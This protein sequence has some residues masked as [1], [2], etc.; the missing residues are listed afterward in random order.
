EGC[1]HLCGMEAKHRQIAELEQVSFREAHSEG[2]SGIVDDPQ[3]IVGGD[4]L[5]SVHIA[6]AGVAMDRH[7][8]RSLWG[9]SSFGFCRIQIERVG[10]DIDENWPDAIP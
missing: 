4:P 9:N 7:G 8:R 3:V 5:N 10:S 1:K 6:R 2:V